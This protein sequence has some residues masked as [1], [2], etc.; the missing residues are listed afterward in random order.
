MFLLCSCHPQPPALYPL[1][2]LDALPIYVVRHGQS[3]SRGDVHEAAV[4]DVL[5]ELVGAELRHELWKNVGNGRFVD[6]TARSEEHTSELQSLRHLV[7]R[8]LLEKKNIQ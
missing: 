7:C 6:V 8:R 4:A 1:S 5:P 3:G 2:L